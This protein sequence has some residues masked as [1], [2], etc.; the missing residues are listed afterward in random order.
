[1]DDLIILLKTIKANLGTT[2]DID[3]ELYIYDLFKT[4]KIPSVA[5]LGVRTAQTYNI[6]KSQF[7]KKYNE[8]INTNMNTNINTNMNTNIKNI[9]YLEYYINDYKNLINKYTKYLTNN[10]D[11]IYSPNSI[12][13]TWTIQ[14]AQIYHMQRYLHIIL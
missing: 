5:K 7:M 11:Y 12:L 10:V 6:L 8:N 4:G 14:Q 2:S 9:E 1:M 3:F 13:L